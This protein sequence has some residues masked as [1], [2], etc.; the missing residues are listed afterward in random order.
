MNIFDIAESIIIDFQIHIRQGQG[1]NHRIQPR[2]VGM[3]HEKH[4]L[5]S[6]LRKD[7]NQLI[8]LSVIPMVED[9]ATTLNALQ[10]VL[11]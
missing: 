4:Q 1:L 11:S 10:H 7:F 9:N 3:F 6:L 2:T 8:V 5:T